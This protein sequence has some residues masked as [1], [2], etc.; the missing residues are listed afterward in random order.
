M[1]FVAV[2][3]TWPAKSLLY[4]HVERERPESTRRRNKATGGGKCGVGEVSVRK[5]PTRHLPNGGS[6][7][8]A[9]R[10]VVVDCL[11]L[12]A[13]SASH[14]HGRV[15]A[16]SQPGIPHCDA[17]DDPPISGEVDHAR[18]PAGWNLAL[19]GNLIGLAISVCN[20]NA[21]EADASSQHAKLERTNELAALGLA[22]HPSATSAKICAR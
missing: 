15:R 12:S 18:A 5:T 6:R 21:I 16:S 3:S 7:E 11:L 13:A 9:T 22:G 4:I 20:Q 8:V 14:L 10:V 19:N 2:W 17:T 1:A